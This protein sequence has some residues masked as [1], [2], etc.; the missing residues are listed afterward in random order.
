MTFN[1]LVVTCKITFFVDC[2]KESTVTNY[3]SREKMINNDDDT[4]FLRP[5]HVKLGRR[6]MFARSR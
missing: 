3:S 2:V 5:Y 1:L 4:K 6:K